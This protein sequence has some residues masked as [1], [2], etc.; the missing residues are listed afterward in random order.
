MT[1]DAVVRDA[2]TGGAVI[3]APHRQARPNL[4]GGDC[5]FGVGGLEAPE[6]Y[7]TRWFANRWPSFPN[8]RAEIHLFSP[9]HEATLASLGPVGVRKVVD[10]WAERTG[11]P[12][13]RLDVAYVLLF[14]NSGRDAG[15]TIAHP[16]GQ[17]FAYTEVPDRPAR[18]LEG[19]C[20]LCRAP[21]PE[22]VVLSVGGWSAWV[23]AA[24][25]SPFELRLAPAT[26]VADL[27]SLEARSR[28]DL[29]EVL[30]N[31]LARLDALFDQPMP[32]MTWIHQRPF[33]GRA[34]PSAHLHLHI[35]PLL[36]AR[37]SL[38]YVAGG[39]LGGGIFVNPVAPADAAAALRSV[40]GHIDGARA[41]SGVVPETPVR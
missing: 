28:D 25:T 13:A 27:P 22:L 18:E 12:G 41:A 14:E 10:L 24:A 19:A 7:E 11:A 40:S 5:P 3:I 39:E 30:S 4:P 29:A 26:H 36:R 16:H 33:D 34:W 20:V 17:A 31:V 8:D 1:G 38:R 2:L 21:D 32:R 23:P 37:G 35:Q 9:D 15:A 6:A